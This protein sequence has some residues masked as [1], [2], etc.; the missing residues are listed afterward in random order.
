MPTSKGDGEVLVTV[1]ISE[2]LKN[3]VRA[4]AALRG[5]TFKR[6]LSEALKSWLAEA[7]RARRR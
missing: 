5:V 6:A 1:A 7:R 3:E 4:A 2:K